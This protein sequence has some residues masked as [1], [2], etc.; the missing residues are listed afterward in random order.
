M[1]AVALIGLLAANTKGEPT[2]GTPPEVTG[3]ATGDAVNG[4]TQFPA[5]AEEET[6]LG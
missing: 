2:G 1:A 4:A 5:V 6:M 3:V